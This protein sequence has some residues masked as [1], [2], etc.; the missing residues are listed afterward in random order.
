MRQ[1]PGRLSTPEG[2]WWSLPTLE[3]VFLSSGGLST[4]PAAPQEIGLRTLMKV[5][6]GQ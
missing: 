6:L 4:V 2:L 5:A 3:S 1:K